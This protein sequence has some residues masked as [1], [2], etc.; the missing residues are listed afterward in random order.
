MRAGSQLYL[1]MIGQ[2][3]L[4]PAS[5]TTKFSRLI[6]NPG[7]VDVKLSAEDLNEILTAV[8]QIKLLGELYP[9]MLEKL[10]GR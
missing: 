8:N 7:A 3:G 10:T 4:P 6:E 2:P 1:I 5:G 9:E